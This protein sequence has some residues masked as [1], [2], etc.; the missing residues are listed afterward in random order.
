[1]R[2]QSLSR[3]LIGTTAAVALGVGLAGYG[4]WRDLRSRVNTL[5]ADARPK[6]DAAVPDQQVVV[7]RVL[8]RRPEGH[9]S[10]PWE[11]VETQPLGRRAMAAQ[12][13]PDQQQQQ[14]QQPEQRPKGLLQQA[15]GLPM[16]TKVVVFG[17]LVAGFVGFN[18][19]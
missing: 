7:T 3:A 2:V 5:L 18:A 9:A 1:M 14:Q 6:E 10:E 4:V 12:G 16:A 11:V 17:A 8:L 13:E 15:K 19:W